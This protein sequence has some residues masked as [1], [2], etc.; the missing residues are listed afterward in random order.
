[1]WEAATGAV[2]RGRLTRGQC[3]INRPF[4]A[5]QQDIPP[6]RRAYHGHATE[7]GKLEASVGR[8]RMNVDHQPH[9]WL[10]FLV[11]L[12]IPVILF[13]W[14]AVRLHQLRLEYLA[15]FRLAL[16]GYSEGCAPGVGPPGWPHC[17]SASQQG[18]R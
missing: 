7:E 14:L 12:L 13:G 8:Q 17:R 11:T 1:M 18:R 4:V 16:G 10:R 6:W 9:R 15:L 2:G 5:R 3:F